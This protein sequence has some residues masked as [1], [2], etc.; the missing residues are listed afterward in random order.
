M[1]WLV[2]LLVVVGAALLL[3][4]SWAYLTANR[5]DR[6]HVRYDLSWQALDAALAR[7]AVVARAVA[8]RV[9]ARI[10]LLDEDGRVL[11]FRGSD[12]AG[13]GS[14]RW[15]F[16]VGGA[17]EPGEE[18]ADAAARELFE[19]TGLRVSAA[20]LVG[21]V[22]RRDALIDFNG[23]VMRSE[24]HFFVHRTRCFDPSSAGYNELERRYIQGH[25]WCDATMIAELDANGE[26][27]YPRQ[28]G[29]LLARAGELADVRGAGPG[30]Q[31][32]IIR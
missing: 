14:R 6:L 7:R 20:E 31:P 3:T 24:E 5:L 10:V 26:P 18:L 17:V 25:R 28:L 15:W 29:A 32:Q 23:S 30:T 11:L 1:I 4:G 21:P 12:P 9:S 22:W 27:V 2:V 13:D 8:Q 19:E 16:T